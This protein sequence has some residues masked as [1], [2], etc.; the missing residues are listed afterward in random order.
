MGFLNSSIFTSDAHV[1][2]SFVRRPVVDTIVCPVADRAH[3]DRYY[4]LFSAAVWN[5]PYGA[6][7]FTGKASK[8][9]A[10]AI[11]VTPRTKQGKWDGLPN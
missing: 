1:V 10:Y 8:G 4:G 11:R 5:G 2:E 3:G 7:R 9:I 6:G